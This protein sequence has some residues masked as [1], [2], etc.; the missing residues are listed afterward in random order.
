MA[1]NEPFATVEDVSTIGRSLTAAEKTRVELLLPLIS[2]ALRH[3]ATKVGKNLNK[4][5]EADEYY[6]DTVKLVTIDIVIRVLRQTTDG[7]PMQQES[8]S[9]LGYSWSGT[10]AIPGGGIA[11]A[12]M[13]NDLKRLG[14]K[15]QKYGVIE[16][17]DTN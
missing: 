1:T 9:A 15:R 5:V 17:Y 11:Q 13:N 16:I 10:Y 7:E 6:A 14:L 4:M 3:E 12:I 2:N 8:Q